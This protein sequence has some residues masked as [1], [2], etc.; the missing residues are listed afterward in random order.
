MLYH[1]QDLYSVHSA[2]LQAEFYHQCRINN[3]NCCLEYYTEHFGR[4]DC[5]ITSYNKKEIIRIVEFKK[6]SNLSPNLNTKQVNKYLKT[7][8]PVY[9]INNFNQI[10]GYIEQLKLIRNIYEQKENL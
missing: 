10:K 1:K 9:V 5:V 2:N 6:H 8:V 7:G 3:I 4:F